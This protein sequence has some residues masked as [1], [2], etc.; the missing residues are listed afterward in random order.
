MDKKKKSKKK[1]QI[2]NSLRK[3]TAPP[4]KKFNTRKGELLRKAKHKGIIE[5]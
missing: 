5:K 3:T 1:N 4:T 2:F